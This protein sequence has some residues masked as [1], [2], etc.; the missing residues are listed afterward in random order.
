MFY[1]ILDL[2]GSDRV[3]LTA[4][5]AML[6]ALAVFLAPEPEWK[7]DWGS[8]AAFVSA[9]TIWLVAEIRTSLKKHP[10]D[11]RL[12]ELILNTVSQRE[13]AALRTMEMSEEFRWADFSGVSEIALWAGVDHEFLDASLQKEWAPVREAIGDFRT[14]LARR[15]M[16]TTNGQ[17]WYSVKAGSKREVWEADAVYLNKASDA[18]ILQFEAFAK[19]GRLRLSI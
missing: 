13:R 14:E 15:S 19:Y 2:L 11:I 7:P 1:R 16:P 9:F 5:L 18:L 8:G 10:H 3:R 12:F 4:G 17:G 6:A